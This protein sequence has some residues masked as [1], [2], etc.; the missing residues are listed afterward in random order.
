MGKTTR[1]QAS[2]ERQKRDKI[3]VKMLKSQQEQIETL[4]KERE[5]LEDHLKMQHE[6]WVSDIRLY[7]DHISQMKSEIVAQELIH[8]LD[9]AKSDMVVGL[10]LREAS[11]LKLM[12]EYTDDQLADFMAWF[13]L[14]RQKPKDGEPK[15]IEVS[16]FLDERAFLW[17]QY[18]VME[19]DLTSKINSKR[20]EVDRA[21]ER[22]EKLLASTEQLQLSNNEK[23]E[24]IAKL[25]TQIAQMETGSKKWNTEIS[26]L[27]QEL[28]LLRKSRTASDTPVLNR[29]TRIAGATTSNAGDSVQNRSSTAGIKGRLRKSG[30]SSVTPLSNYSTTTAQSLGGKNGD[31]VVVNKQ[32]PAAQVPLHVDSEKCLRGFDVNY[33]LSTVEWSKNWESTWIEFETAPKRPAFSPDENKKAPQREQQLPSIATTLPNTNTGRDPLRIFYETL[34]MESGL[35]SF[36]AAKKVFERKQTKNKFS[37]PIKAIS[38]VERNTD[39]VTVKKKPPSSPVSLNRRSTTE[40]KVAAKQS[41]KRKV[42]DGSSEDDSDDDFSVK[43]VVKKPK[44][45]SSE[46]QGKSPWKLRIGGLN[47]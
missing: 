2:L 20:A 40:S 41:R 28:E 37:S 19:N 7:E 5:I 13:D 45:K 10:K 29:C 12:L 32:M 26:R 9:A 34:M 21:N 15:S 8:L 16:A 30:S 27:T 36:D 33:M 44:A 43:K 46:K 17:N 23:D 35:L 42:D 18:K 25:K 4:V 6:K 39:S 3:L 38:A 11:L 24:T 47:G 31:N 1:S 22:I 14:L